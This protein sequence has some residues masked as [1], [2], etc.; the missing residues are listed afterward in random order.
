[1]LTFCPLASG[2][3]GNCVFMSNGGGALLIDAG[4]S[5]TRIKAAL[6]SIGSD[7]TS[8]SAI[9]LTHEH[10]DHTQGAAILSRR[11]KIPLFA[12]EGTWR[13]L[14]GN[15]G[16]AALSD[17]FKKTLSPERPIVWR[18]MIITPFSIPHDAGEPVG[19]CIF[20]GGYKATVAT[21]IGHA[22][23]SLFRHLR[24]SDILLLESN[25]D[26]DMLKNGSYPPY[27]KRRILGDNGHLSNVS[28][29][30]I[31]TALYTPEKSEKSESK[32]VFLGHLSRENNNPI[33]AYET[34]SS[35][36]TAFGIGKG[37]LSLHVAQR[38]VVSEMVTVG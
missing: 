14:S 7:I 20:S 18:D 17:E 35:I 30:E 10:S 23:P 38:D 24:D 29:G 16:V 26:V 27:L 1:M 6:A 19:Y 25:H 4:L 28:C 13:A 3:S 22:H 36:L 12:T 32:H 11:H 34:V 9:F 5:G 31:L 8:V 37:A 15:K 2:S 33:I 21:D